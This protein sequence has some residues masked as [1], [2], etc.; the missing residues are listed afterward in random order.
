MKI[1]MINALDSMRFGG[2]IDR[3]TG[4]YIP[5]LWWLK[6]FE[7]MVSLYS[8]NDYQY[9]ENNPNRFL[10]PPILRMIGLDYELALSMGLKKEQFEEWGMKK[11][12]CALFYERMPFDYNRPEIYECTNEERAISKALDKY[13]WE[14]NLYNEYLLQREKIMLQIVKMWMTEHEI[15]TTE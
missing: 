5:P 1:R 2:Y 12:Y 6:R 9:Y 10:K 15:E 11:E 7:E 14:N 13:M 4:T 8:E 3:E